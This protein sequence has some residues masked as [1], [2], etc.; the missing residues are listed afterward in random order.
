M[1]RGKT[2]TWPTIISELQSDIFCKW[3]E[4]SS[5]VHEL[6]I[7]LWPKL[8]FK[9]LYDRESVLCND[10]WPSITKRWSIW[11]CHLNAHIC[12]CIYLRLIIKAQCIHGL[13]PPQI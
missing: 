6:V 9:G 4:C 1:L 8:A 5:V 3:L 7:S 12:T 2:G 13:A 10:I 11:R